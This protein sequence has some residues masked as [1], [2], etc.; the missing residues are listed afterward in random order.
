[1]SYRA[2]KDDGNGWRDGRT[3]RRTDSGDEEISSDNVHCI[4]VQIY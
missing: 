1:M 3:D 2:N 4:L